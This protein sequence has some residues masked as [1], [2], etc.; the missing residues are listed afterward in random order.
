LEDDKMILFAQPL[1]ESSIVTY[2]ERVVNKLMMTV[3]KI[4]YKDTLLVMLPAYAMNL[5]AK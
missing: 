3:N 2:I 4:E 1:L 5:Q